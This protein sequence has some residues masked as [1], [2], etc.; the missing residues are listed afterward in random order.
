[1]KNRIVKKALS[2]ALASAM[3]LG[4]VGCGGG[5]AA[6]PAA[7]TTAAAPADDTAAAPAD[8]T[9]AAPADDGGVNISLYR[10]CFNTTPDS[11]KTAQ[12]Q[13]AIN[14]YLAEKGANVRITLTD[15]NSGEYTEKANLALAN[16][17]INLLWTASWEGTIGTND[18]VPQNSVYDITELLQGTD[19]YASM[20]EGQWE[21]TKYDGKNYFIPVYKDNVEGYDFMFRQDF[22]DAHTDLDATTVKKLADLEPFLEAAKN[23][24]LKYPFLTQKTAMFYRWYINDFD[25][26]T[27]DST[28][29]WVAVDRA[30]NSVVDTILTPQYKEFCTLMCQWAEKG[31]I[32]EDDVTK[33]TTDTTTQ[34][35]DWAVSWWTDIPVNDEADSRYEQDVTMVPA[36]DRW[37]HSNSALGSCYCVTANSTEEQAKAAIEFMGLLYT[38]KKLADMYTFG[39]EGEDFNYDANGHVEQVENAVYNHSMWES[40]SATVVTPL[41]N[42][43][44]NKAELYKTFNG[45]ANTSSAAGFRFDKAPVEAAYAACQNVFE[46]YGFA[47]ENGGYPSAD[48]E[49]VIEEYQAALDEAGYQDVLAEFQKQYDAWK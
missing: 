34:T 46:T 37:A 45:G 38:D 29:N 33:V 17:E 16:N 24:G 41:S 23:D 35:Q 44:D 13:D 43:P 27:A 3:V 39:I 10:C 15:I 49:K 6:A 28:A 14:A 25:F 48:V 7:D 30:S 11:A 21:A 20:D 9:A 18:L 40:A 32:S 2:I 47:L 5:Q 19:L 4:M 31:Y 26:F 12:V 22:L 36:T 1:M 8:D 42:E